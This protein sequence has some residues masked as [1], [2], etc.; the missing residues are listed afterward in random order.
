VR[1]AA[2]IRSTRFFLRRLQSGALLLVRND[3][4]ERGRSHMTAFLSDDDG[5]SWR[6]GLLLDQRESPYTDGV[7][8]ANG[9]IYVIYD[10][11][12]YTLNRDGAEGVGS[13]VMAT[14]REEDVRAGRPVTEGVRLRAVISQLRPAPE[15]AQE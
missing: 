1:Q 7:Q 8:A 15:S 12:R 4:P 9:A 3:A 10:H 11:Q 2:T 5:A 6:G 13:V 14:F